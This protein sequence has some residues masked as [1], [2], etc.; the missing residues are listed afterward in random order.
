MIYFWFPGFQDNT[1]EIDTSK[2][3]GTWNDYTQD[4]SSVRDKTLLRNP[5]WITDLTKDSKI[6]IKRSMNDT[7]RTYIT[8]DRQNMDYRMCTLHFAGLRKERRL[9]LEHFL[10]C[11]EGNY[12]GYKDPY[13]VCHICIIGPNDLS[14]TVDGRAGGGIVAGSLTLIEDEHSTVD[15]NIAIVRTYDSVNLDG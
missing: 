11:A 15:L 10:L 1:Q 9:A 12:I 8:N 6:I 4:L 3:T 7:V 5:D 14:F 2:V 13:G